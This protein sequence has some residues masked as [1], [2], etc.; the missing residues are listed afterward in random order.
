M[1]LFNYEKLP[2]HLKKKKNLQ[3]MKG[4]K[5]WRRSP[6]K[7]GS[8]NTGLRKEGWKIFFSQRCLS[9]DFHTKMLTHFATPYEES[10]FASSRNS[11]KWGGIFSACRSKGFF[12]CLLGKPSLTWEKLNS[13]SG[14]DVVRERW[15]GTHLRKRRSLFCL[16]T[17]VTWRCGDVRA[18]GTM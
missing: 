3:H 16:F 10:N 6:G 9:R 4:K 11:L 13:P 8:N 7:P 18:V 15:I 2:L 17:P 14:L 1:N 5:W 12:S